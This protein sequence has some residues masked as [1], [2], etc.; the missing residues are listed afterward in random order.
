MGIP[1][2]NSVEYVIGGQRIFQ[3]EDSLPYSLAEDP[4]R[5]RSNGL[6]TGAIEIVNDLDLWGAELNGVISLHRTPSWEISGIVGVRY[7][8]LSESLNL[9]SVIAGISQAYYGQYGVVRDGFSTKNRFYGGTLGLRGSY[10]TGRLS[11]DMTAR[12][13]LGNVDQIQNIAGGYVSYNFRS[14]YDAGTQGVFAQTSNEGRFSESEF[15]IVPEAQIKVGYAI[16]PRLRATIAY[17]FLFMSSV[18]RPGDNMNRNLPKGQ[19]FN[20]ADP[21]VSP[22]SPTRLY[23]TTNFF[24]HGVS[25]GMEYRF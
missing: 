14:S 7:L 20:Q 2:Y 24:A 10:S 13:A 22:S 9:T 15:A 6:I 11:L 18:V 21:S 4:L 16:T 17:D 12:V 3:G 1:V 19:T 23:N 8:E 25:V 5:A